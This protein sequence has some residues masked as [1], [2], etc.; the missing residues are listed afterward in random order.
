MDSFPVFMGF[1]LNVNQELWFGGIEGEIKRNMC[2]ELMVDGREW[3]E[4][5]GI[6][7]SVDYGKLLFFRGLAPHLMS[8]ALKR[9]NA[10]PEFIKNSPTFVGFA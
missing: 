9:E 6:L 8:S 2:R 4:C 1:I 7:N 3:Q 10:L 5:F